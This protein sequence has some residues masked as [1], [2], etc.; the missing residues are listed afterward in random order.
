MCLCGRQEVHTHTHPGREREKSELL[1]KVLATEGSRWSRDGSLLS[2]WCTFSRDSKVFKLNTWKVGEIIKE[3][4]I[5]TLQKQ[6]IFYMNQNSSWGSLVLVQILEDM[7]TQRIQNKQR[8]T[9]KN[10]TM[11]RLIIGS[12]EASQLH[13]NPEQRAL[14][15]A[16]QLWPFHKLKMVRNLTFPPMCLGFSLSEE[17]IALTIEI[18]WKQQVLLRLSQVPGSV[19]GPGNRVWTSWSLLTIDDR[20]LQGHASMGQDSAPS[21]QER[22]HRQL[23]EPGFHLTEGEGGLHPLQKVMLK[24]KP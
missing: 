4:P 10:K 7:K 2:Y 8:Q 22:K 6:Y 20:P 9:Q 18:P 17:E 19:P 5:C 1:C 11:F 13:W 23:W 12:K 24:W 21:V 14:Q 16:S 3:T 15:A